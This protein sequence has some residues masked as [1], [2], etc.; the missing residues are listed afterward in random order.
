MP[1][2]SYEPFLKMP[3]MVRK[4]LRNIFECATQVLK[5]KMPTMLPKHNVRKACAMEL[6]A[7]MGL[8][9]ASME[10]EYYDIV[11]TRNVVL[12]KHI[13]RSN[14]HRK[15]YNYCVVYSFFHII[16]QLEYKVSIIMTSR[17]SV[18]AALAKL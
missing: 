1:T 5:S 7:A 14:D 8:P 9:S 17:V 12:P 3:I 15:G 6:N 18:G 13:D 11:L 10:F 2:I 16:N 4:E